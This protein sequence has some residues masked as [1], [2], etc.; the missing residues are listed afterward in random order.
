M[1][2]DCIERDLGALIDEFKI[3]LPSSLDLKK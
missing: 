2:S 3:A 1:S